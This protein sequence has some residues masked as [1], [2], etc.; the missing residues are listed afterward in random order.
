LSLPALQRIHAFATP[1]R[2]RLWS[3]CLFY[4]ANLPHFHT[5]CQTISSSSS[6][7]HLFSEKPT[8]ELLFSWCA[9]RVAMQPIKKKLSL[10]VCCCRMKTRR[11]WR[12]SNSGE[13]T[14]ADLAAFLRTRAIGVRLPRKQSTWRAW[15]GKPG[16]QAPEKSWG[17]YL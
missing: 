14:I 12:K 5:K 8:E 9:Q 2:K 1:R 4:T 13:K 17:S 3:V 15:P 10:C 11:R 7:K 16:L 6:E